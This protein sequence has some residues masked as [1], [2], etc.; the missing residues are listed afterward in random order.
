MQFK[1]DIE[2]GVAMSELMYVLVMGMRINKR[3]IMGSQL[4]LS[5]CDRSL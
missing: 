5:H 3:A 1:M 2:P 4:I